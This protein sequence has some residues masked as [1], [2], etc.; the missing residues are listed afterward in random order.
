MLLL[1]VRTEENEMWIKQELKLTEVCGA[2]EYNV[3]QSGNTYNVVA[4]ISQMDKP[5]KKIVL[6]TYDKETEAQN[7]ISKIE[8]YLSSPTTNNVL[9]LTS[10]CKICRKRVYVSTRVRGQLIRYAVYNIS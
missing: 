7:A 5:D 10:R 2:R 1:N 3:E 6:V 4:I 9:D 8:S